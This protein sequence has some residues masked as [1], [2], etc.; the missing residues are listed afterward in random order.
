MKNYFYFLFIFLLCS[1]SFNNP[2]L[3]TSLTGSSKEEKYVYTGPCDMD[4]TADSIDPFDAAHAI[5]MCDGLISA[6]WVLPDGSPIQ[7]ILN[8]DIGHG[9]LSD[10]GPNVPV[11]EG[12]RL[13]ALSTGI[14]RIP[15]Y[16]DYF[17]INFDKLY[18][19]SC[20]AGYPVYEPD[21]V[22]PGPGH[23]GIALKV[24]LKMPA[25]VI[26]FSLDYK[27]YTHEYPQWI[28]SM[29]I[30]QCCA[31]LSAISGISPPV[32]I[33]VNEL[34]TSLFTTQA[35]I[36]IYDGSPYGNAELSGTGFEGYGATRWITKTITTNDKLFTSKDK[37]QII[38]A[39]WDSYDGA[40]DSTILLDNFRWIP[41]E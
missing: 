26:G 14:A 1:C 33:L 16:P 3:P 12:S 38:F 8:F 25:G 41:S 5:G 40:Y 7:V 11:H 10:F 6:E 28:K 9:I 20:P 22:I 31:I 23:D 35:A 21:G 32:N 36:T 29:Y 18:T 2:F 30:D 4:L 37:I 24:V 15:N 27:F 17:E 13:L 19:N 39:I 34:D